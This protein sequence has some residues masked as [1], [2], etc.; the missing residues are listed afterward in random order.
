M[1]AAEALQDAELLQLLVASQLVGTAVRHRRFPSLPGAPALLRAALTKEFVGWTTSRHVHPGLTG[2]ALFSF[3]DCAFARSTPTDVLGPW[4]LAQLAL[5]SSNTCVLLACDLVSRVA[6]QSR[7]FG[8]LA[9][10]IVQLRVYLR[11]H[12]DLLAAGVDSRHNL[13]HLATSDLQ[14]REFVAACAE[15]LQCAVEALQEARE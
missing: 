11:N 13:E 15:C 4:L 9:A 14:A 5:D 8:T 7:D 3:A 1:P 12:A 6:L 10:S 2:E